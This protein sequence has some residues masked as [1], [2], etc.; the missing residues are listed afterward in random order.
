MGSQLH[1]I[2]RNNLCIFEIYPRFYALHIGHPNN[3]VY[4]LAQQW[5]RYVCRDWVKRCRKSRIDVLWIFISS[6]ERPRDALASAS[7]KVT[8]GRKPENRLFLPF[9]L[10][11]FS[12]GHHWFYP[13]R[14]SSATLIPLSAPRSPFSS[15]SPHRSPQYCPRKITISSRARSSIGHGRHMPPVFFESSAWRKNRTCCCSYFYIYTHVSPNL[16]TSI[17]FYQSTF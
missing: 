12:R 14:A 5:K 9:W 15:R 1:S 13:P 16:V 4:S 10:V 7:L 6:R 8:G 11:K 17:E 3:H 2:P